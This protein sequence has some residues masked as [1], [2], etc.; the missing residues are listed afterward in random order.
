MVIQRDSYLI[1]FNYLILSLV[2]M[3]IFNND[4]FGVNCSYIIFYA[5]SLMIFVYY[6]FNNMFCL[7]RKR[8]CKMDDGVI[9]FR[10]KMNDDNVH[11]DKLECRMMEYDDYWYELDCNMF[12]FTI[13]KMDYEFYSKNLLSVHTVHGL[14]KEINR[15]LGVRRRYD[16]YRACKHDKLLLR[17]VYTFYFLLYSFVY[18]YLIYR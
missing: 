10:C 8:L 13:N 4:I 18:F 15:I 11:I 2:T 17:S 9:E 16:D 5:L 12:G 7:S 6:C 14:V 1:F 3:S